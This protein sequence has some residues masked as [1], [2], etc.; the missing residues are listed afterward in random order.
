LTKYVENNLQNEQVPEI[1]RYNSMESR[2]SRAI[3]LRPSGNEKGFLTIHTVT[4]V[5]RNKW[6]I[7]MP[8]GVEDVPKTSN[9]L[10]KGGITFSDEDGNKIAD[11]D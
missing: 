5:I 6:T 2:T 7:L 1:E 3:A 11:N 8:K 9:S 10:E 4:R